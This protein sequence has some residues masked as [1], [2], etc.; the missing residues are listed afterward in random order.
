MPNPLWPSGRP[1]GW[2]RSGPQLERG[3]PNPETRKF[4]TAR[5]VE[6]RIVKVEPGPNLQIGER[7]AIIAPIL[8]I[9]GSGTNVQI[10]GGAYYD[11]DLI[12]ATLLLFDRM[13]SPRD[14]LIGMPGSEC[15]QGLESWPGFGRTF[16]ALEG[17]MSV[18]YQSLALQ[19][20]LEILDNRE[21]GRW[22]LSRSA[23]QAGL[24]A[25]IFG[26]A[27]GFKLKL[28]NLLPIPSREVPYEDV[29]RF[30]QEHVDELM[31]LRHHIEELVLEVSREGFGGLGETIALEK[32]MKS[33]DDYH[34]AIRPKNF[35][36]RLTSLDI[37]I[38]LNEAVRAGLGALTAAA[39]SPSAA[40]ASFLSAAGGIIAVDKA[41]SLKRDC[42]VPYAYEYLFKAGREL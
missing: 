31:A 42:P 30:R 11:P 6:M 21:P 16:V 3:L 34:V 26:A 39:V 20:A 40:L 41:L 9:E 4:S 2:S 5:P 10:S 32:F 8:S 19:G 7:G 15:P 25:A 33:L 14:N 17:T 18:D 29:L 35:L 13:D 12:R 1:K 23:Q 37:S 27:N 22:S 38:S 28:E 36:K 24:P